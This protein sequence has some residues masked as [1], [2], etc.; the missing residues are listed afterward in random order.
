MIDPKI[1]SR[2]EVW[3]GEDYDAETRERVREMLDS[4]PQ[5]LIDSFYQDL[6]FGTGGLRGIM[7]AGTNRMNKYTVGM[8]T[9]GLANYLKRVFP[10]NKQIKVVIAYDSRNNSQYFA[11][12][13]AEVF[14]AN[15]I[16]V[17]LFPEL[18]P[19]PELSFA[20]R[21]LGCQSGVMVTASHNPKEYNGYKA[22]WEDG[23]QL[24]PPHD[25]N[26]I[27]E[28][29]KIVSVEEVKFQGKQENI[30]ILGD[31]IDK[32]YLERVK[33]L[34]LSPEAIRN[35]S[36][37]NIVFTPLHGTGS[38]MVPA[39]LEEYGFE[40]IYLVREQNIPDGNF[41]T[42][43]SPNPEE[44]AALQMAIETADKVD[45]DLVM[46][47][48]PDGD[49]VGIA[50]RDLENNFVL[51]NGN[52]TAALLTYYLLTKWKEKRLLT[53]KEYIVKTIVTSE[54]LKDIAEKNNVEWF[55]VLTGFKWIA[56]L[57]RNL[58]GQKTYIG[59]GEESYGFMVGDFVRD[60]DAVSACAL[61][62][63]TAAWAATKGKSLYELLIDIYLEFGLYKE[64]LISITKKGK[65]GSEEIKRMMEDLRSS[66][67]KTIN[68]SPVVVIKDY[69]SQVSMNLVTGEQQPI[70]LPK[71]NVLQLFLEDGSKISMRPSG[72]EPKIKFYFGVKEI[73]SNREDFIE[74]DKALGQ[75]IKDI[76]RDM[77]L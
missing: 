74:A 36:D 65:S 55:D 3:L 37:L 17:Y 25:K 31:E 7:G 48:D 22:Y 72:T 53:G 41:P 26:V 54:L 68:N 40:N 69:L 73:L 19:T 23:S 28:V 27:A 76:I 56:E 57:I 71:S 29:Q 43:T 60:K 67:P 49:R 13:T 14:S 24:V 63:E 75:R 62:A 20:I 47:T 18:R 66:P 38:T 70:L 45:A 35:H 52:Q 50:V 77:K 44:P 30:E 9:Q 12:I 59:G 11:R 2:A 5:E 61:I 10:G 34:S 32:A 21:H 46:A 1:K 58:E 51:L 16:Y 42:V 6:E 8:A 64:S 15:D 33:S 39:A 4:N